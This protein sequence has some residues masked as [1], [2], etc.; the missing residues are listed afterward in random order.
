MGDERAADAVVNSLHKLDG[1]PYRLYAFSVMS[2]HVHAVFQ[3][4]LT[5]NRLHE[6]IDEGGKRLWACDHPGLSKIMHSLKGSS[7]Y[8]CNLILSRTGQFWEH[9]S[10]DHFVREGRFYATIQYVLNN[11]VKAGLVKNWRDWRWNFCRSELS[12]KF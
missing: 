8:E 1:D 7:A 6:T 12:E 10:F 9:E 5:E 2:N 11:P 3:P 4:F